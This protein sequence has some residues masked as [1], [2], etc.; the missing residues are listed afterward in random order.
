MPFFAIGRSLATFGFAVCLTVQSAEAA[1]GVGL[2][3]FAAIDPVGGAP[4]EAAI[5]Y[6]AARSTTPTAAGPYRIAAERGAP[7]MDARTPLVILSHGHGGSRWGHHDLAERLADAGFTVAAIEHPGDNYRDQSGAGTERV[8]F[9]RP[10]Q[11]SALITALLA[12]PAFGPRI[13]PSKIGV[14]GFSMGG[15][16]ALT[17]VGAQPDFRRYIDYC[18]RVLENRELCGF[19]VASPPE[20]KE[21]LADPRVRAAFAMAPL[22]IVF[23]KDDLAP[24]KVPVFLA[25]AEGDRVLTPSENAARIA[26]FLPTLAGQR[27]VSEAGHYVFLAP[28]SAQLTATA[29]A[30]CTDPAGVDRDA[31][32]RALNDDAVT[33]FQKAFAD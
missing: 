27:A 29:P 30:L 5:F 19:P 33:F 4:M 32:H 10:R 21:T 11:V 6:P 18:R 28:C 15:Y 14:A 2:S 25:Y 17:L 22:A 26:P 23:G 16:T 8:A 20:N 7:A 13:D 3:T 24:I 12:D 1:P 31:V 9:G